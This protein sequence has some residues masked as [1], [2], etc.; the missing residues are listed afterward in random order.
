MVTLFYPKSLNPDR[1]SQNAD[2]FSFQI[3]ASDMAE[4]ATMDRGD[5]VAWP[6]GDPQQIGLSLL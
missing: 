1:M 2:L 5:G 6:S 3:D 4:I